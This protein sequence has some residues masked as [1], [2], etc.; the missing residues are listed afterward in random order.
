M[1]SLVEAAIPLAD[2]RVSSAGRCRYTRGQLFYELLR[3]GALGGAND[4]RSCRGEFRELLDAFESR[5]GRLPGLI[6]PEE[7]PTDVDAAT[8]HADV[9]E[10]AVPRALVFQDWEICLCFALNGF[11]RRLEVA[12]AAPPLPRHVCAW[13]QR[14]IQGGFP[15]TLFCV[16]NADADGAQFAAGLSKEFVAGAE[17]SDIGLTLPWA[18]RLRVEPQSGPECDA[19]HVPNE[20]ERLL[21]ER[22]RYVELAE[23]RPITLMQW[24]YEQIARGAEDV[25]FG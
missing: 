10:Y 14:Q 21:L 12:L 4:P 17:V 8:L 15:T 13:L 6:R 5:E 22:G 7:L 20:A 23:L 2:E 19:P 9:L 25:G 24:V 16:R 11:H 3:E 18:Y 1:L